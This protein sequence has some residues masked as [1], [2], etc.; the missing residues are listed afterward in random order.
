[1][2]ITAP[3]AASLKRI[4]AEEL[5]TRWSEAR[6]ARDYGTA[7]E[8]RARVRMAGFE[9]DEVV[10]E[11]AMYGRTR[12]PA[13]SGS[14]CAAPPSTAG[15]E[16]GRGDPLGYTPTVVRP[17]E[18]H[19]MIDA[20]KNHKDG[21]TG[22]LLTLNY[23]TIVPLPVDLGFTVTSGYTSA[24][25]EP[26]LALKRLKEEEEERTRREISQRN[27]ASGGSR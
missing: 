9:P 22:G 11:I 1:V 13:P 18:L 15:Q 25:A 19:T 10:E 24:T 26:L 2:S 17:A 16:V 27:A 5:S 21:G 12:A 7:D 3:P 4:E 14:R 8:L 20:A 23:Q 6:R